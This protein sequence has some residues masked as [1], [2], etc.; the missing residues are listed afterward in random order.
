LVLVCKVV[1]KEMYHSLTYI[2]DNPIEGIIFETFSVLDHN[3]NQ[4][5]LKKDGEE[6]DVTDENKEA[7]VELM[8]N[9]IM[10][11]RVADERQAT[12]GTH[13]LR[14]TKN[15][16]MQRCGTHCSAI[17]LMHRLGSLGRLWSGLFTR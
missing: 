16:R 9:W 12:L 14:K 10:H 15:R 1:D 4:V 6:E 17:S 8:A 2:L 13:P 5:E 11:K 7:Y 3:Q